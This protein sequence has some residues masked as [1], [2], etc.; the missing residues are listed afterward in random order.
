[1]IKWD[2]FWKLLKLSFFGLLIS[3]FTLS[4]GSSVKASAWQWSGYQSVWLN[5]LYSKIDQNF[6]LT[7]LPKWGLITEVLWTSKG[8]IALNPNILFWWHS[9]NWRPYFYAYATWNRQEFFQWYF[10]TYSSCSE[11][12]W[13]W[14]NYS[15]W[16]TN[17]SD[18]EI[19]DNYVEIFTNFFK[20]VWSGDYIFYDYHNS[21]SYPDYLRRAVF[22]WSS[23]ELHKS[24]CFRRQASNYLNSYGRLT[25]Y[26][27]F[28]WSW[29]SFSTISQSDIWPA[30][31]QVWYWGSYWGELQGST[32]WNY[33]NTIT[34]DYTYDFCTIWEIIRIRKCMI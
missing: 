5:A 29:M 13:D 1:M 23:H 12:T 21:T 32:T 27:M 31:W 4:V 7:F 24:L 20:T 3:F 10:T 15:G 6:N 16:N 30:P 17:C 25:W 26:W 9:S 33:N 11:I 2:W 34:W 28:Y 8:I 19:P 14:N 18:F 22:C